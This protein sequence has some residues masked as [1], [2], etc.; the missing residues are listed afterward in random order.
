TWNKISG[1][2]GYTVYSSQYNESTGK[3]SAWK[4]RGTAKSNKFAWIDKKAVSGVI[5]RYAVRAVNGTCKSTYKATAGLVHLAQPT[6][7]ISNA[8]TGIT[9]KWSKEAGALNYKIYRSQYDSAN[10]IWTKWKVMGTADAGKNAWTDKSVAEGV[11]YRYTV[12]S[13]YGK[14]MSTYKSSNEVMF[15]AVPELISCV[16]AGNEITLE[17]GKV[18]Y[19]DSYRIYRKTKYAGWS[20]V[21]TVEGNENTLYIDTDVIEGTVY[22]YTVRA[23]SANNVSAYNAT[24]ISCAEQ[25]E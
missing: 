8:A 6:V 19:A 12:R 4:N 5:Y 17:Y 25:A 16:K 18:D 7:T 14:T 15:L 2:A 10:G 24:G 21:G 22:T 1:A 20:L 11:L 3:W 13:A 9:V 23:V